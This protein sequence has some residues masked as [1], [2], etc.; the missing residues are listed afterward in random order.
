MLAYTQ[1]CHF[2]VVYGFVMFYSTGPPGLDSAF[3]AFSL[4]EDAGWKEGASL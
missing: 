4:S 3:E 2:S 1:I